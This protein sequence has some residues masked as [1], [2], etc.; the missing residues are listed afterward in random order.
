MVPFLSRSFRRYGVHILLSALLVL[1]TWGIYGGIVNHGFLTDWDD[2]I[3]VTGNEAIRGITPEHLQTAFSSF[4]L[5]NYSPIQIVSYMIDYTLWGLSA[6]GFKLTNMILHGLNG[7]V[8]YHLLVRLT[9]RTAP[10]FISAL[11]FLCHPVQ[12]ESVAWVSQRKNLL[13]MLFFLCA[14]HLYVSYR[15]QRNSRAWPYYAGSQAAFFVAL[16]AK[17]V[18][19]I[20]PIVMVLYDLCFRK[21]G[22][23][24]CGIRDKIP[25]FAIAG[26]FSILIWTS[27]SAEFHGGKTGY[28]GGSP[29]ATF[30]TMV[31]VLLRYLKMLFWPAELSAGYY[32][33]IITAIDLRVMLSFLAIA[34]LTATAALLYVRKRELFF[35]YALFFIALLPVSQIV[36]LVT[37]MNDRYL[38]FPLLGAGTFVVLAITDPQLRPAP[39]RT[40]LVCV[41]CLTLIPLSVTARQRTEVW[42]NSL[43]LWGDTIRKM[44][45]AAIAWTSMGTACLNAGKEEAAID[46]YC[47]ALLIDPGNKKALTT[48]GLLYATRGNYAAAE[49]YLRQALKTDPDHAS[50]LEYLAAMHLL[51]GNTGSAEALCRQALALPDCSQSLWILS[52]NVAV[53]QQNMAEA[54]KCYAVAL[55]HPG[56]E[57]GRELILALMAAA[58]GNL[59]QAGVHMKN[60]QERRLETSAPLEDFYV[61][62]VR[63]LPFHK[64]LVG[65]LSH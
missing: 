19:V 54:L 40:V 5:G 2:P 49:W 24:R 60:A 11:V 56:D 25:F 33:P 22:E 32:I 17:P 63:I 48:M 23:K 52:G 43:A 57:H 14:F 64:D 38:Y 26:A 58:R 13:A 39:L 65:G 6:F 20:F 27:Q 7:V 8:F 42:R 46:N 41:L 18:A 53:M 50:P 35:W 62:T 3:Y 45:Q 55:E 15:E 9:Q 31:T 28:H 51:Q 34:L 1:L 10:A 12:V 30:I 36:P 44:P 37:L 16:L 21:A 61:K 29:W 59:Q 4:Y 47:R